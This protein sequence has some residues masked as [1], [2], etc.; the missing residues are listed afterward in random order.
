MELIVRNHFTGTTLLV[1]EDTILERDDR[2]G[3]ALGLS[4]CGDGTGIGDVVGIYFECA[5]VIFVAAIGSLRGD[6]GDKSGEEG[7]RGSG[8]ELHGDGVLSALR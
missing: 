3:G 1:R 7:D 8:E 5:G 4:L 6:G 2:V